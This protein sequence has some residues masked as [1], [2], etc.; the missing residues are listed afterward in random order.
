MCN[1]H[2]T[3]SPLCPAI[4]EWTMMIVCTLLHTLG[5]PLFS[6]S[7]EVPLVYRQAHIRFYRTNEEIACLSHIRAET[8]KKDSVP[9]EVVTRLLHP[10]Y[11]LVNT[12]LLQGCY[13]LVTTLYLKHFPPCYNLVNILLQSCDHLVALTTL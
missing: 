12:R 7:K 6:C 9:I 3:D 4:Y 1:K 11:N 13:H 5:I 8:L 2:I 10:G